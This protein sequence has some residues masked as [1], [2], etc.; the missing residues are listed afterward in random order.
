MS[1]P[2]IPD[3]MTGG[4]DLTGTTDL[5]NDS[6]E[7]ISH[8][9]KQPDVIQTLTGISPLS[10][11]V[12]I[13]TEHGEHFH[14]DPEIKHGLHQVAV[15]YDGQPVR[16]RPASRFRTQRL[17]VAPGTQMMVAQR[18]SRR[19]KLRLTVTSANATDVLY[20]G[21]DQSTAATMGAVVPL[22]VVY[23][24]NHGDEV[25]IATPST[26]NAAGLTLSI[27]QEIQE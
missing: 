5:T 14:E 12:H 4:V 3:T 27:V 20:V 16:V 26:N 17:L 25:G 19:T 1:K 7:Y 22:N 9:N 18:D 24:L 6:P 2:V 10:P 23:D 21:S 15:R 13:E 11:P 8:D